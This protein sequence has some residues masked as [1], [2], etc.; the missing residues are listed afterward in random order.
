MNLDPVDQKSMLKLDT[1]SENVFFDPL[2]N[3]T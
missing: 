3:P 2:L 1:D